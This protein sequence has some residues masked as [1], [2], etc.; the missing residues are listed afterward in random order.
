MRLP[1]LLCVLLC[2]AAAPGPVA[3]A[4][5]SC[6]DLRQFYT[7]KGFTLVGVPQTEISGEHLTMCPQ[8]PTCCTSTMEGN[9]ANVSSR[10]TEGL[11]REAGRSLQA[12]F[13][14]LHRSFDTYFT[15]LHGR[16]ERSLQKVLSPLGTLYS[17]NTRLYGDLYADLRQYYR[18][19]A[20]NLDETLSDF[21]SRLLELTFKSSAPTDVILSEDYL[22]CVAKQQETLRPFG[23]IPRDMKAKVTRAFVTA[24][25]FVQAL[26]ISGEVVRKVSQV[27]LSSE[28]VRALMKLVYCPHCHGLASVKPCSNY[29]SNVM[30][31]CLANQADLDPEWQNLIDTMIQVAASF[32]TEPS[33]D[34]VLSSIPARIYEAV[35]YQQE[36]IDTITAKVYQ[37]CGAPGEPGTGSP[38]LHEPS[39]KSSSLTASEYKPSPT[40]ELRLGMQV[41]DL[42]SNLREMRQYWIQ[43]PIALCSKMAV[44]SAGQD[45]CWNGISKARYLPEVMGDGLA[46]QINNPEVELDITKPD[47]TIRQQIMQ[48]KITSNRLKN[49]L[50]GNDVDFQD[51]SDDNSG[52]GSG[53]CVSGQCRRSTTGSYADHPPNNNPVTG[54]TMCQTRLSSQLLLLSLIVLLLQR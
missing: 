40:D 31:G 18:G 15:E 37:T 11:I 35:H 19:S 52:S 50:E 2:L 41:S 34:V 49:A 23:D 46:N 27:P 16:S 43:V 32:S 42:S 5:R 4:D 38:N 3:G 26:I 25:S 6:A 17:Q 9:L 12:S 29:C 39:R 53:M 8:G 14:A 44:G 47:M 1:A 21:W 45:K 33:L 10:E 24:R 54:A 13:N 7:G 30:K 22:E 28:C 36:N 48:L 20:L 51:A